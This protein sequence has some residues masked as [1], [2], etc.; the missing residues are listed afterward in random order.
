MG[1]NGAGLL[2]TRGAFGAKI[3]NLRE[4][5]QQATTLLLSGR[6][7][8]G[9]YTMSSGLH[10][11]YVRCSIVHTSARIRRPRLDGKFS[12][13][14]GIVKKR[15]MRGFGAQYASALH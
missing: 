2:A 4:S 13:S 9:D 5:L 14:S 15:E 6:A 12:N 10:A 1:S 11:A 3:Q 7:C 8:P